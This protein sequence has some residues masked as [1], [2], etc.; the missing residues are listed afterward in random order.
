[1]QPAPLADI[2]TQLLEIV[3]GELGKQVAVDAVFRERLRVPAETE[4]LEPLRDVIRHGASSPLL[5]K[6]AGKAGR[7]CLFI[8]RQHVRIPAAER[9]VLVGHSRVYSVAGSRS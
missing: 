8:A 9:I 7:R 4:S 3:L 5:R 2:Q 6:T 1:L